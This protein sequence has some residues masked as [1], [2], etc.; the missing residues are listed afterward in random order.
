MTKCYLSIVIPTYNEESRITQTL[1]ALLDYAQQL[2]YS[3]EIIVADDGS[4]DS[5]TDLV[6]S[7]A[8]QHP[9]IRLVKLEHRGKGWA[10]KNGRLQAEGRY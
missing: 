7:V 9:S 5:T 2:D 8:S 3:Y 10:I 4:E 1:S 6:E